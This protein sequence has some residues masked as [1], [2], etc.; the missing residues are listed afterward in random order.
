MHVCKSQRY[1]TFH[2]RKIDFDKKSFFKNIKGARLPTF[3][4]VKAK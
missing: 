3:C 4:K 2:K 1:A